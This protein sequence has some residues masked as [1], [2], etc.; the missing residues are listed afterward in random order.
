MERHRWSRRLAHE[1]SLLIP[2]R[3]TFLVVS[4]HLHSQAAA[5]Q[6]PRID[7]LDRASDGKA[8]INV[9]PAGDRVEM[10]I[11]FYLPVDIFE[12]LRRQGGTRLGDSLEGGEI[13]FFA[14]LDPFTSKVVE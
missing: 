9:S 11:L 14:R 10:E 13:V 12:T 7:G 2:D 6:L 8:A 1:F 4:F 5:L 3:L